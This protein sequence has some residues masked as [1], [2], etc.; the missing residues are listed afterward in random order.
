MPR[1]RYQSEYE[2][3]LSLAELCLQLAVHAEGI[4]ELV[5]YGVTTPETGSTPRDWRFSAQASR[6][7][8]RGLRLARDLRINIEG[9]A[10]ALDL[11]DQLDQAQ[12]RLARAERLLATRRWDF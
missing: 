2:P 5:E 10:L 1:P 11:L 4:I 9:I 8:A 6:R 12:A 3:T 7:A